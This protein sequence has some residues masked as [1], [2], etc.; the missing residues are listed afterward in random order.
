LVA[1]ITILK[2]FTKNPMEIVAVVSEKTEICERVCM[3]IMGIKYFAGHAAL[4]VI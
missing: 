1:K 4:E 3:K 2:I